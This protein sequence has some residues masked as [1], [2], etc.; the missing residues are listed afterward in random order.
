[1]Y[2]HLSATAGGVFSSFYTGRNT[3]WVI[4]KDYPRALWRKYWRKIIQAQCRITIDALRAW[5]GR[6]ARARLR[7]QFAGVWGLPRWLA[8]RRA[9]QRSIRVPIA[10]IEHLLLE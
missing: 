1:L 8:K 2:H 4:A 3:I 5:R 7:G 10:E 6:E 9:V